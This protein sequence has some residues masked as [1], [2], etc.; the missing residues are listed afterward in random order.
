[1]GKSTIF[2]DDLVADQFLSKLSRLE[3]PLGK[4]GIINRIMESQFFSDRSEA[5]SGHQHIDSVDSDRFGSPGKSERRSEYKK[6]LI[7]LPDPFLPT[8]FQISSGL[9]PVTG[10][11]G[12]RHIPVYEE[13]PVIPGEAFH[14]LLIGYLQIIPGD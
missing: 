13:N 14:C 4:I 2:I 7:L 12:H 9:G 1:M 5:D 11:G 6:V 3:M 8:Q 10:P